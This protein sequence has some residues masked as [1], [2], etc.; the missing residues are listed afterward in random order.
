MVAALSLG[1]A[2]VYTAAAN[3]YQ[4]GF[5]P[6]CIYLSATGHWCPGCGGLRATHDILRGDFGAA[7]GMNPVVVLVILPLIVVSMAWWL[8]SAFGMRL[9]KIVVPT[10]VAWALPALLGVFWILRNIPA[11]EPWLA[12]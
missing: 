6:S 8:L 5:F 7:M 1:A 9:P 12:P 4:A 10:W 3:P 11:L 2:A